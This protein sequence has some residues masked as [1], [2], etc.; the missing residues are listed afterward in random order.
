MKNFLWF[1]KLFGFPETRQEGQYE[2]QDY[3]ELSPNEKKN[4]T[5][6]SR[7]NKRTFHVGQFTRPTLQSI[8]S[9]ALDALSQPHCPAAL[10]LRVSHIIFGDVLVEHHR[11]PLATFQAASQLNCL[12]F[13]NPKALPEHGITAYS[14]DRTQG[15]ACALAC[16]AGT[17]YR[18]YFMTVYNPSTGDY[19]TGQRRSLQ[20]N[21]LEELEVALNNN[22][23]QYWQVENGY[24]FST[25][26]GLARLNQRLEA[27]EDYDDL[28]D[29]VKIGWQRDTE[30]VFQDR[31]VE[32]E[33]KEEEPVVLV[34]Q[35][36]CSALSVAY[37]GVAQ[38]H[39]ETFA[40]LVLEA[41]YEASIW[42]AILN[43]VHHH[44]DLR[45]TASP[46]HHHN[47]DNN[48]NNNNYQTHLHDIRDHTS[49]STSPPHPPSSSRSNGRDSDKLFLTLLGGG[50]F[51]NA[52]EWIV[53]SMARACIKVD[54]ELKRIMKQ[55][56]DLP[57]H[58]ASPPAVL[59]VNVTH[60]RELN[61]SVAV[62]LTQLL[63][64]ELTVQ[65]YY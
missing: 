27:L 1:E 58:H 40:R 33:R 52:L 47:D 51:G 8:R 23:E 22:E 7:Q 42:A 3:F 36:Y 29:L 5:M 2:I 30:V 41:N 10:T 6:T 49:L 20:V 28:C 11:Y 37:S 16:P 53:E 24:T 55:R 34:S 59:Y 63:D 13:P 54:K 65:R 61:R 60:F 56:E 21:N 4:I 48:N 50:V 31:F 43:M 35:V 9:L 17:L 64:P 19:E 46:P 38:R 12:E 14:T 45:H 26:E 39:W 57:G 18:N 15:P 44:P 62:P 32:V 25:E